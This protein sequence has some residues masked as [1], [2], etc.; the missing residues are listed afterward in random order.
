MGASCR[1]D[2]REK[3]QVRIRRGV[4]GATLWPR[5]S[6]LA[7]G[8]RGSSVGKGKG[9]SGAGR[10]ARSVDHLEEPGAGVASAASGTGEPWRAL[11]QG[12][13]LGRR[14]GP[15]ECKSY[16]GH[17]QRGAEGH[18]LVLVC[19]PNSAGLFFLMEEFSFTP[20]RRLKTDCGGLPQTEALHI[21]V[22]HMADLWATVGTRAKGWSP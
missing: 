5:G 12:W 20:S 6:T 21:K 1:R 3:S 2:P 18:W 14:R 10:W 22:P 7:T 19:F 8:G 17:G 13:F 11:E 15:S 16:L 9:R 4:G